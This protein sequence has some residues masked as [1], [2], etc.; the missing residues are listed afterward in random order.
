[1]ISRSALTNSKVLWLLLEQ[2]VC[3][4]LDWLFAEGWS[5]CGLL[6]WCL[7]ISSRGSGKDGRKDRRRCRNGVHGADSGA[8]GWVIGEKRGRD[9]ALV[10]NRIDKA[11]HDAKQ[12]SLVM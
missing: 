6:C 11:W 5:F 3:R 1:M 9:E 10:S 12:L 2:W 8:E 7:Y 4:L